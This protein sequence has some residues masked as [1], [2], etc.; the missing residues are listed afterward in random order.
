MYNRRSSG[1]TELR[2]TILL[3]QRRP[4]FP[5]AKTR[6]ASVLLAFSLFGFLFPNHGSSANSRHHVSLVKQNAVR[7]NDND[8][9]YTPPRSLVST[10]ILDLN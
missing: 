6:V 9:W 3:D 5:P 7:R 8:S 2:T 4:L 10:K 1:E